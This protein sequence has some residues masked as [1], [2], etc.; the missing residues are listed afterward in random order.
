[1]LEFCKNNNAVLHAVD[2][3]PK[4]DVESLKKQYDRHFI[5]HKSLSLNAIPEIKAADVFLIDGDHNWY[6]VFNELKLIEKYAADAERPFPVIMLHDIAWP[7]GRRDL[8]YNPETIPE[9]FR[10]PYKKGGIRSGSPD[11]LEEGGLNLQLD[12][13]E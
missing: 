5:F 12:L 4:F 10:K 1:L 3:L 7:Y 6:T 9:A 8:Y 2:P 13:R 11:L